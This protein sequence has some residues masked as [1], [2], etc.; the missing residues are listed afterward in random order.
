M[1]KI[2]SRCMSAHIGIM[3]NS[4][5]YTDDRSEGSTSFLHPNTQW[6]VILLNLWNVIAFALDDTFLHNST[7]LT[8]RWLSSQLISR[9]MDKNFPF[10]L[11]LPPACLS[12]RVRSYELW[13][14]IVKYF[15][16]LLNVVNCHAIGYFMWTNCFKI[17]NT[18][19][20]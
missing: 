3:E 11:L 20:D 7:Q 6:I 1:L 12:F 15:S 5:V 2:L 8:L 10:L 4:C 18:F 13:I 17:K 9:V 14:E 19:Q 16:L